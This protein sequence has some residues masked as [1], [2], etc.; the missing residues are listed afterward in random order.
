MF[1]VFA[2]V[3]PVSVDPTV[4][5]APQELDLATL[6]AVGGAGDAA[7]AASSNAAGDGPAAPGPFPNW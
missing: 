4:L 3:A 1:N 6:Q 7:A 5:A 2:P